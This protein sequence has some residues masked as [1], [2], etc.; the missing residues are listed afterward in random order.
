MTVDLLNPKFR[1]TAKRLIS[2]LIALSLASVNVLSA[3]AGVAPAHTAA[4]SFGS[5]HLPLTGLLVSNDSLR[6]QVA[7]VLNSLPTSSRNGAAAPVSLILNPDLSPLQPSPD[8]EAIVRGLLSHPEIVTQNAEELSRILGADSAALVASAAQ[9]GQWRNYLG[10]GLAFSPN[11][12]VALTAAAARMDRMFDGL[13]YRGDDLR[14]RIE[15]AA[16]AHA[17]NDHDGAMDAVDLSQT[18]LKKLG[19][20]VDR[21]PQ[22]AEVK[23]KVDKAAELLKPASELHGHLK[24]ARGMLERRYRSSVTKGVSEVIGVVGATGFS[25]QAVQALFQATHDAVSFLE[26]DD[27]AAATEVLAR[28]VAR[29]TDIL[30][31]SGDAE[32]MNAV[33]EKIRAID[34]SRPHIDGVPEIMPTE[35]IRSRLLDIIEARLGGLD[36][37]E[38]AQLE[39]GLSAAGA[40]MIEQKTIA[41]DFLGKEMGSAVAVLGPPRSGMERLV[42]FLKDLFGQARAA[43]GR[44]LGKN[45]NTAATDKGGVT[46]GEVIEDALKIIRDASHRGEQ[47]GSSSY[48]NKSEVTAALDKSGIDATS[49]KLRKQNSAIRAV[50]IDFTGGSGGDDVQRWIVQDQAHDEIGEFL[51]SMAARLIAFIQQN[52]DVVDATVARAAGVVDLADQTYSLI[53]YRKALE[54]LKSLRAFCA[55]IGT[56]GAALGSAIEQ[57]ETAMQRHRV[58]HA[59]DSL[60]TAVG[61]IDSFLSARQR[62]K[63]GL[64]VLNVV[65]NKHYFLDRR[66]TPA[67]SPDDITQSNMKDW[68][69]TAEGASAA[70]RARIQEEQRD[71]LV[72]KLQKLKAS[73]LSSFDVA[74][75]LRK[76]VDETREM[77]DKNEDMVA[78]QCATSILRAAQKSVSEEKN[79]APGIVDASRILIEILAAAPTSFDASVRA[80][81]ESA[82]Q[83]TRQ[84]RDLFVPTIPAGQDKAKGQPAPETAPAPDKALVMRAVKVSLESSLVALR[85]VES[86]EDRAIKANG[87]VDMVALALAAAEA[88]FD[89]FTTAL[90]AQAKTIIDEA[91]RDARDLPENVDEILA[92]TKLQ[93]TLGEMGLPGLPLT[94]EGNVAF[95]RE[96]RPTVAM[97][98]G[99]QGP[100]FANGVIPTSVYENKLALLREGG[101]QAASAAELRS[102]DG[103]AVTVSVDA[104][105]HIALDPSW[106]IKV[107]IPDARPWNEKIANPRPVRYE[108]YLRKGIYFAADGIHL[109]PVEYEKPVPLGYFANFMTL[110]DDRTDGIDLE[111]GLVTPAASSTR[112]EAVINDKTNMRLV[113]AA[114]GM[115]EQAPTSL[116]LFNPVHPLRADIERSATLVDPAKVRAV[117]LPQDRGQFRKEILQFLQ[118]FDGEKVVVKASGPQFRASRAIKI[119]PR[120][121]IDGIVDHAMYLA[122]HKWMTDQGSVLIDGRVAGPLVYAKTKK[123]GPDTKIGVHGVKKVGIE[124]PDQEALKAESLKTRSVALSIGHDTNIRVMAYR[125][126]HGGVAAEMT[127]VR[128]G[129]YDGQRIDG[130]PIKIIPFPDWVEALHRQNGIPMSALDALEDKIL[131][132][133]RENLRAINAYEATL[134][135]RHAD[136][137]NDATDMIGLDVMVDYKD[138]KLTPVVIEHNDMDSGG[139]KAFDDFHGSEGR[140]GAHS[141]PWIA[142]MI[143]RALEHALSG[144]GYQLT[145]YV[146]AEPARVK[147]VVGLGNHLAE[148]NGRVYPGTRHNI[149]SDIVEGLVPGPWGEM[150]DDSGTLLGHI[151]VQGTLIYFKAMTW[152]N[153]T[154]PILMKVAEMTGIL[155][156]EILL[157]HDALDV[158]L[159]QTALRATGPHNGDLAV[160]SIITAMQ[161]EDIPRVLIGEDDGRKITKHNSV[162]F[163]TN[164]LTPDEFAAFQ[165]PMARATDLVRQAIEHGVEGAI[166]R[167][168]E[169][170]R[171]RAAARGG[172]EVTAR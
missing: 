55:E 46:I 20:A 148:D 123:V 91:A 150:R 112:L 58:Y 6:L 73:P 117:P 99:E 171:R 105:Q 170:E 149:G 84:A 64:G 13:V 95:A 69:R 151:F 30:R 81:M 68:I 67:Q 57:A 119:F 159:G 9:T 66:N 108:A 56:P 141:R 42:E 109:I 49:G 161:T 92:L 168:S 33:R 140:A 86:D 129:G 16:R 96:S 48:R 93:V 78:L 15:D 7:H 54:A 63:E 131:H 98:N 77:L 137:L 28:G 162:P 157:V 25:D 100:V 51:K 120:S 110:G 85:A 59:Q 158:A 172:A 34:V 62:A 89:E 5:F 167:N 4:P 90:V 97:P 71:A 52:P 10:E 164:S 143:Y 139:Q 124:Y 144:S 118:T 114:N 23:S 155:P 70:L 74:V 166:R 37:H 11:D 130:V 111:N 65:L 153:D 2:S 31:A 106:I 88:R 94:A 76:A 138:G 128:I 45:W 80:G 19:A 41:R 44:I 127:M 145:R 87:A 142:N 60:E 32:P 104:R 35:V 135:R 147:M 136:P 146:P 107:P 103:R 160:K 125:T 1:T 163:F 133:A 121:D 122:G 26:N 169:R 132:I 43:A 50:K 115:A 39:E 3:I 82:A 101:R 8:A 134:P 53:A 61:M 18:R 126:P 47:L 165:A 113:M 72:R 79:I 102:P 24:G 12:A 17:G 83:F 27:S 29:T 116:L 38:N 152:Y 154:G 40:I 75:A 156:M 22:L 14:P 36:T 21:L